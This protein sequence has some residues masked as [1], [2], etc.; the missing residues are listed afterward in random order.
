[1]VVLTAVGQHQHIPEMMNLALE[2]S[3]KTS[4][5]RLQD[6]FKGLGL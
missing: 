4:R 6:F 1:V 5:A 2:A 3:P